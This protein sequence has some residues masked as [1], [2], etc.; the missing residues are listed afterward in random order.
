MN[1]Q[2]FRVTN[3]RSVEDSG[4]I[5]VSEITTL[6]GENEAGKTNLLLPLW[7]FNPSQNGEINLLNDM[8]RSKFAKMRKNPKN[9]DFIQCIFVLSDDE[10]EIASKFGADYNKTEKIAIARDFGGRIGINFVDDVD[11]DLYEAY[12]DSG[13]DKSDKTSQKGPSLFDVLKEKI[14]KFVYYS[15]YGNLNAQIFLPHVVENLK[16]DDLGEKEA[17]KVRTLNVLFDLV[18]LSANEILEL[19][20]VNVD[21][22]NTEEQI[23]LNDEK[24]RERTVLLQSASTTLTKNFQGWWKQR[25]HNFRLHADGNLFR[26]WVSDDSRTE[27]IELENRSSGLQWFFSFYLIFTYESGGIHDNAIL[28][29]DEPG[30][31]LHPLAQRDLISYFE[32]LSKKHQII[33]TTQS[34]FMINADRLDQVRKIY[35]D[36][37]GGTIASSNLGE[38]P[39]KK[40]ENKSGATYAVFSALNL[41]VA[42]S[43]LIGC[44]PIIVEGPSDQHYMTTIKSILIGRG[45]IKPSAELVFPPSGGAHAVKLISSILMGRDNSLPYVLLDS[46]DVGLKASESLKNKLYKDKEHLI[47][48]V[49]EFLDDIVS[50]QIEDLLPPFLIVNEI[51]RIIRA[52]SLFVDVYKTGK[53]IVPQ[54]KEWVKS[55]EEK[56][57][58]NWKVELAKNVKIKLLSDPKEFLDDTKLIERWTKLFK[59]FS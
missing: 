56:L 13:K 50:G 32:F 1:L 58:L 46:D 59:K 11:F 10:R 49:D 38:K 39:S 31:S 4:W 33:F 23:Q 55:N 54:I 53:P 14:P 41:T 3:F 34:P 25:N 12:K 48:N 5:D 22:Q 26:I 17:A 2:K 28:L 19:A 40:E 57:P 6:I 27:E 9:F 37:Q 35:V 44:K 29:L 51:D 7:K 15:N 21:E 20:R 42:E 16:R 30:L 36:N 8:P 43:L 18:N 52:D 24:I 45:K 47:L